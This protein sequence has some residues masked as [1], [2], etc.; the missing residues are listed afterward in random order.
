VEKRVAAYGMAA[1][2]TARDLRFHGNTVTTFE[3]TDPALPPPR[4]PGAGTFAHAA[5]P[6]LAALV[7]L[8]TRKD[9]TVSAHGFTRA[10]LTAFARAT[11]GRGVDR[12]V[13]FGSA[14]AFAPVWD[15][16]DLLRE[17]TRLTTVR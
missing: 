10:E 2:G 5:V 1:D 16:Y 15:G 8:L 7:P 13:P 11:A 3:L 12:I 14:L 6:T 17:F 4:R 9:Q